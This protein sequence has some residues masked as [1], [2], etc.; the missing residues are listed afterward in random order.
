MKINNVNNQQSFKALNFNRLEDNDEKVKLIKDAAE[1]S[2]L[3][4]KIEILDK[5]KY[6]I[7]IWKTFSSDSSL[8]SVVI[9]KF[10]GSTYNDRI[11][12]RPV[13]NS[14]DAVKL[15]EDAVDVAFSMARFIIPRG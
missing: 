10:K 8:V 9:K 1:T 5:H 14:V 13:K 7:N 4:E 11:W 15:L 2:P 3:K 6:D 12:D